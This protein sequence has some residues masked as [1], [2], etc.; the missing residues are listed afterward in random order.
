[1]TAKL[2]GYEMKIEVSSSKTV[3]GKL[4]A[5]EG[6]S[7]L[8]AELKSSGSASVIVATGASQFEMLAALTV[9]PNIDWSKVTLFHLDEYVGMSEAHPASFRRYLRERFVSKLPDTPHAFYAIDAEKDPEGECRRLNALIAE[10]SICVAFVG[11]GENAHLAFNDPPADFETNC[12]YIV[13]DLDEGCRRQ[14][15]GEGWF[16]TLEDVPKQ[17]ISMSIKQIMKSR[18]II[19][20]VPDLRKAQAVKSAV[21]GIVSPQCPASILQNHARTILFLDLDSSSLLGSNVSS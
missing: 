17:A 2:K 21:E 3:M 13:V 6:A 7:E 14:Q 19:C 16:P 8:R 11:I 9:E 18:S 20:T 15:F 1:M 12:P 5:K 10:V 4:A